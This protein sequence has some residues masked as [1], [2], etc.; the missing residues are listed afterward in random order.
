MKAKSEFTP[1]D[2]VG[3]KKNSKVKN[4]LVCV[5]G[6]DEYN[7]VSNCITAKSQT[8]LGCLSECS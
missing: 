7:R 5:L 6:P 4:I 2:L 8:N 3:L 1:E